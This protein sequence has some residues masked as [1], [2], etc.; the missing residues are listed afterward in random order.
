VSRWLVLSALAACSHG[1]SVPSPGSWTSGPAVPARRTEPAA[2]TA[3]GKV[4]VIGGVDTDGARR[5]AVP[6]VDVYDPAQG[7]WIDGPPLPADG[8]LHHVAVATV[9]DRLFVI[10]G[11]CMHDPVTVD[12]W[13][14][15]KEAYVLDGASWRP[16]APQPVARGAAAAQVVDGKIYVLGGGADEGTATADAAMYDP[17]TDSW[18]ALPPMPTPRQHVASCV[19]GHTIV[20]LGGWTGVGTETF[21]KAEAFDVDARAWR[22]GPP[23]PTARGGHA[24]ATLGGRC[25]VLGG[26]TWLPTAEAYAVTEAL[27][28]NGAWTSLAPLPTK[29]HGFGAVAL[30]G[31]V[32]AISGSIEPGDDPTADVERFA[33]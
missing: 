6:R 20:V 23:M 9:D 31:A 3:R 33:P 22:P 5:V 8:P 18:A 26:E 29:R 4:Y 19:F 32:W 24:A 13:V 25:Y 12:P 21:A 30:G 17:A 10:G 16:V 27:D 28:A 15:R 2:A 7:K 1:A 14:A 11:F